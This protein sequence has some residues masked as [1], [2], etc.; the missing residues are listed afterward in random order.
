VGEYDILI[1]SARQSSGLERWLT[2]HGYRLPPGA[3]RVLGSYLKQGMKF[4]VAKVNLAEQ[5]RLG[6]TYLRPI[7]VAYESPRFMLPI[8]LGMVNADGPQELFVY[9]LT[10]QG[11]VETTNYRNVK[12]P[13]DLD[14]PAFV[15]ASFGDFYRDLFAHQTR[16]HDMG[17]VFTEYVWDMSGCDPCAATPLSPDELRALGVFWLDDPGRGAAPGRP[18]PASTFVTR[19]HVRYDGAHF[20]EDLVFQETADRT[21]FQGR[22]VIR[23]EWQGAEDCPEAR[24]Y[25]QQLGARRAKEAENLASLTGWSMQGIRKRMGLAA[26]WGRAADGKRSAWWERLWTR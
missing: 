2:D 6:F 21:S 9:A 23:H 22:Y 15:K 8:R 19:L 26:D 18:A 11:R 16:K 7:Q 13:S 10:R 1:L 25:R 4:F 14:V 20:P 24:K 17:V 12:L 5:Q 3:S